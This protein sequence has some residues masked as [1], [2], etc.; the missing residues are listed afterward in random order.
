MPFEPSSVMRITLTASLDNWEK[1]LLESFDGS[2]PGDTD[3]KVLLAGEPQSTFESWFWVRKLHADIAS[4]IESRNTTG[5]RSSSKKVWELVHQRLSRHGDSTVG[6]QYSCV[7]RLPRLVQDNPGLKNWVA[8]AGEERNFTAESVSIRPG[9]DD[10]RYWAIAVRALYCLPTSWRGLAPGE[11]LDR[12]FGIYN[13]F[14]THDTSGFDG[15]SVRVVRAQLGPKTTQALEALSEQPTTDHEGEESRPVA[16]H[17]DGGSTMPALSS[18]KGPEAGQQAGNNEAPALPSPLE[19]GGS[20]VGAHYNESMTLSHSHADHRAIVESLKSKLKLDEEAPTPERALQRVLDRLSAPELLLFLAPDKLN[21]QVKEDKEVGAAEQGRAVG[22]QQSK[23]GE[24]GV[25]EETVVAKSD[26]GVL[27]CD[28]T[29]PSHCMF[30]IWNLSRMAASVRRCQLRAAT[31]ARN[32]KT[33]T[34]P[35]QV[36]PRSTH[37]PVGTPSP[38]RTKTQL[39]RVTISYT[40]STTRGSGWSTYHPG[41]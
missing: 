28:S 15:P 3:R 4:V 39:T 20:H 32:H 14:S 30:E 37:P 35:L 8:S 7:S 18:T 40:R 19:S 5:R 25:G 16:G 12:R 2:F 41:S 33:D 23:A 21:E 6:E 11:P 27:E 36:G 26:F 1:K 31:P 10:A 22:D 9:D 34:S 17:G 38:D 13:I 29:H 24:S